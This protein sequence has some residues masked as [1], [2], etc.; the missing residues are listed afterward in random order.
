M[1][2]RAVINDPQ[3]TIGGVVG[4]IV[5]VVPGNQNAFEV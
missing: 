2:V 4:L 1:L 5:G 3:D